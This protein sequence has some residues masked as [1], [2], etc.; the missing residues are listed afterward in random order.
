MLDKIGYIDS[1]GWVTGACINHPKVQP[2]PRAAEEGG[3][4]M[5]TLAGRKA[6]QRELHE[7]NLVRAA[8]AGINTNGFIVETKPVREKKPVPERD[9]ASVAPMTA[10]EEEYKALRE[11]GVTPMNVFI[12]VGGNSMWAPA[13]VS[14]ALEMVKERQANAARILADK[15]A[16]FGK[17]REE[18]RFAFCNRR[19]RNVTRQPLRVT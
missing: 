9:A 1:K 2:T 13:V 7:R 12:H 4:D 15:D 8:A 5:T 17:L 6:A 11:A 14:A 16:S 3:P 10:D 18:V 19:L